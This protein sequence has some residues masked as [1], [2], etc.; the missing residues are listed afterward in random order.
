MSK[1]NEN[2]IVLAVILSVAAII[3]GTIVYTQPGREIGR[4]I[5]NDCKKTELYA[6]DKHEMVRSIYDCS[7]LT[8]H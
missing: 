4:D 6:I 8:V 3:V 7:G 1:L 2:T 5:I